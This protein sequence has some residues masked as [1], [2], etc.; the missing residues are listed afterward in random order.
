[1]ISFQVCTEKNPYRMA[2]ARHSPNVLMPNIAK[3]NA[4]HAREQKHKALKTPYFWPRM[5]G[6]SRPGMDA[7]LSTA[8]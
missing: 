2:N 4:P 1:M 3:I 7:A 8:S 5:L 6:I